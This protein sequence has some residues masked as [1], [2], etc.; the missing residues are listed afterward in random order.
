MT[1]TTTTETTGLVGNLTADPELRTSQ[2]GKP[3]CTL[4]LA[5]KPWLRGAD[6]QPEPTY[7]DIVAFGLLAE[8]VAEALHKGDRVV[9]TGRIEEEPWTG[10]DGVE[11]VAQKVIADGIGPDL[12]FA[13]TTPTRPKATEPTQKPTPTLDGLLGPEPARDYQDEPF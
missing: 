6:V 12:R 13:A 4:R 8:H 5:V 1:T 10:R 2:A 7:H 11:R 9:V 3:W